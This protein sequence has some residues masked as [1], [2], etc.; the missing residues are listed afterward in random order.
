MVDEVAKNVPFLYVHW[1]FS[2]SPTVS[3]FRLSFGERYVRSFS[4][5][6]QAV[7][8]IHKHRFVLDVTIEG[9]KI[10]CGMSKPLLGLDEF[11][12][13][14]LMRLCHRLV[15]LT[16]LHIQLNNLSAFE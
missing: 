4:A 16:P 2:D 5:S 14:L 8:L 12:E 10:L 6:S 1:L 15:S 13:Y 11:R 7:Q 9:S 3:F